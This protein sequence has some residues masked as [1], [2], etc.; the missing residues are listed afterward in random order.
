MTFLEK[1]QQNIYERSNPSFL[2]LNL[3]EDEEGF[4]KFLGGDYIEKKRLAQIT[5]TGVN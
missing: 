1:K 5:T 2:F 4:K 3:P